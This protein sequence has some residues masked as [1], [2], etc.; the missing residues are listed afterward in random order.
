MKSILI[1]ETAWF[2]SFNY[3]EMS[4]RITKEIMAI[5]KSIGEKVGLIVMSLGMTTCGFIIGMINGWSL[6]LAMCAVGPA[7]GIAATCFGAMTDTKFKSGLRA[8]GQ[9]AGYAEQALSSIKVVVAFGM[10]TIEIKNYSKYLERSKA[11]GIKQQYLLALSIGVFYASIYAS[12]AY[13]FFI[14]GIWIEKQ[15]YNHILDRAYMG[16]DILAVFWGILFGFFALSSITPHVKAVS[17][18]KVAGKFTYDVIERTP[19]I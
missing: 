10:E 18:G 2:D 9:S 14:G 16:G 3:N 15:Y 1:Q 5:N 17:E 8:Y 7:I 4:A 12:Y 6:A 11:A 19:L 13:A